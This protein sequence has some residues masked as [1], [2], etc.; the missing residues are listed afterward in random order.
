MGVPIYVHIYKSN[1]V[2]VCASMSVN[3]EEDQLPASD[4]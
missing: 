4:Y 2:S 3:V 1:S